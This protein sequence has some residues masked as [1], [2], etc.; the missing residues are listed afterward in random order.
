MTSRCAYIITA[1]SALCA[2]GMPVATKAQAGRAQT[3]SAPASA[4]QVVA[5]Q[6][7]ITLP[8][9]S[10]YSP[11]QRR[12]VALE[13]RRSAA[14]ARQDTVW[15]ATLYATDFEGVPANGARVD[16]AALFRVFGRD[17]PNGRFLIDEL[18]VRPLGPGL[19]TVTGRLRTT[20][21]DGQQVVAES[22]YLHV[23]VQR[24]GHW[25][26]VAAQGTPVAR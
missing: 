25:W 21:T 8:D 14:I 13:V 12:I 9:T 3:R 4:D 23:Y 1:V 6:T 24:A 2:M 5:G 18:A 15:L 16:R 17:N 19:A 26:I 7:T 11:A 10:A 22:R 20:T